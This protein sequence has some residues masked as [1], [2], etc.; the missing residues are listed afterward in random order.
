VCFLEDIAVQFGMFLYLLVETFGFRLGV[1]DYHFHA[2]IP[3]T[4][5]KVRLPEPNVA[6]QSDANRPAERQR[7]PVH[8]LDRWIRRRREHVRDDEADEEE[9][10]DGVDD[11][12][13]DLTQE[14]GWG[15]GECAVGADEVSVV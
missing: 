2:I 8:R 6:D 1:H 3:N 12:S 4:S 15:L 11:I 5:T 13:A 10:R 7:T 14:E 9:D